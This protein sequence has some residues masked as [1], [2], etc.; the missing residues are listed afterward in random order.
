M[1]V[2]LMLKDLYI[3]LIAADANI[4]RLAKYTDSHCMLINGLCS[5]L[6]HELGVS[7]EYA[8]HQMFSLR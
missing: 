6:A 4:R 3:D 8:S 2:K 7:S 1:Q 5:L